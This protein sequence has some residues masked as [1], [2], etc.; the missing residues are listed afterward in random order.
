MSKNRSILAAWLLVFAFA[1]TVAGQV[2]QPAT[3]QSATP[4]PANRIESHRLASKLTGREMPYRVIVPEG[5]SDRANAQTRYPVI[6]LLHG[7]FGHFD[8]WTDKTKIDE[9]SRTYKFIIVTPEGADGW[10]T[11]SVS[12]PADKYESYIVQELVPK[13]DKEF[14]T[15]PDRKSR[16]IAGLSM[17][18][19]G[20]LKFGLKYPDKF[21][22]AGSFSGALD[23]PLRGSDHKALRPSITSV[24]GS[25]NS[26]TRNDNDIFRI[27][28]EMPAEKVKTLPFLYLDC[29]TEDFLL[30]PNRDFAAL[31]ID[32]KIP[33]EFRQ[34]PGGHTWPYWEVQVQEF[35][36]LA[37]RYFAKQK[38]ASA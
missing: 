34:L 31:L 9:F 18:G 25:D 21:G 17:G 5:Y 10:Y 6:Y 26:E 29:G 38:T 36:E 13:I 28:R 4:A 1:F 19:Y 20:A 15:V 12:A 33:H 27:V 7:L 2:A 8:N 32:K 3:E 16:A 14:R 11:D 23:A 37:D 35:L 24:Y 30:Q 22:L